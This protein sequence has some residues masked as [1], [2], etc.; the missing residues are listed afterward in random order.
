VVYPLLSYQQSAYHAFRNQSLP[1]AER[2]VTEVLSI[3]LFPALTDAEV[4]RVV[5]ACNSFD[6]RT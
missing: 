3:P 1:R 2:A 5:D 6:A 4:S